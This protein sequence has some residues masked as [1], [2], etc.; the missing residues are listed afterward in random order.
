VLEQRIH[1]PRSE[2]E[3]YVTISVGIAMMTPGPDQQP[4]LLLQAAARA[5]ART[6]TGDQGAV[7]LANEADLG[8][9]LKKTATQRNL[10][11]LGGGT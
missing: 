5:L 2:P 6:G 3:K 7:V 1:H 11:P 8:Q 9:S 10:R 4:E